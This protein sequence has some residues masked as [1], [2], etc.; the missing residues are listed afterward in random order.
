MSFVLE[1]QSLKFEDGPAL[2]PSDTS[3]IWCASTWSIFC[4]V[5]E[6]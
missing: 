1:L 4:N 6:E 5:P 2:S 3:Y